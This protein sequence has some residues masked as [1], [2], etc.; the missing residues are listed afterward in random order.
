MASKISLEKLSKT[1]VFNDT[2]MCP[3]CWLSPVR[4][5][6]FLK[7]IKCRSCASVQE[8]NTASRSQDVKQVPSQYCLNETAEDLYNNKEI[9]KLSRVAT[10]LE[11]PPCADLITMGRRYIHMNNYLV[12]NSLSV[13]F[14]FTTFLM[15]TQ[16]DTI[17]RPKNLIVIDSPSGSILDALTLLVSQCLFDLYYF[18]P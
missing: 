9:K 3:I 8:K 14:S 7:H 6:H 13:N 10:A 2:F 18:H 1:Q 15:N 17:N 5:G 11:L 12:N 16:K 4:Q